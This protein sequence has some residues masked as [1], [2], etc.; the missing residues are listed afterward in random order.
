MSGER[1]VGSV[2]FDMI[3]SGWANVMCCS[4][5]KSTLFACVSLN[6]YHAKQHF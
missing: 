4:K 1:C 5:A 2:F 6:I 3:M